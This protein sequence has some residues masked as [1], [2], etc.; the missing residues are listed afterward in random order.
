LVEVRVEGG[1]GVVRLQRPERRN[2]LSQELVDEFVAAVA[3]LKE[4]GVA[5]ARLEAAPPSFC[6]GNDLAELDNASGPSAAERLLE[7]LLTEP[8]FW[9]A[10]IEGAAIGAG[11][12]VAAACPVAVAGP[13]AWFALTERERVGIFPTGVLVHLEQVVGP[14]A[15]FRA[16]FLGDR[17]DARRALA[18]GLVDD[19]A[20]SAAEIAD[21]ADARSR[22]ALELP[23]V[24]AA[25]REAWQHRW[26]TPAALERRAFLE[27]L[28][29]EQVANLGG[30]G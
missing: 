21:L 15:A 7:V 26:T 19:V 4:A 20:G 9:I 17:I 10:V 30:E 3:R 11:V 23:K 24:T 1:L 16:G 12:A 28:L 8:I 2:A 14:R 27:R 13:D 29:A 25:A 22:A 5:V 18:I 6:A